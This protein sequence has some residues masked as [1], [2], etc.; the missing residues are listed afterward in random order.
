MPDPTNHAAI[1]AEPELWRPTARTLR[2]ALD[3]LT[4]EAKGQERRH[5]K[6]IDQRDAAEDALG[7]AY[8]LVTGNQPEWSNAFGYANALEDITNTIAAQ[9]ER[10]TALDQRH[11]E[12]AAEVKRLNH[13][14]TDC[15]AEVLAL[16]ARIATLEHDAVMSPSLPV[17][18]CEDLEMAR[19]EER[20]RLAPFLRHQEFCPGRGHTNGRIAMEVCHCGLRAA[21][22]PKEAQG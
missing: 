15:D 10:I 12:D 6:T 22:A 8:A 20:A 18:T 4:R 14:L 9:S 19:T 1:P 17:I 21:L 3:A 11:E 16:T 13:A 7:D 2:A 5:L